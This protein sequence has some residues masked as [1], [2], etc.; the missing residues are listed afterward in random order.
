[1]TAMHAQSKPDATGSATWANP[2]DVTRFT[3]MALIPMMFTQQR[4]S[5]AFR[6]GGEYR[7]FGGV[8]MTRMWSRGRYVARAA[9]APSSNGAI[10]LT[11]CLNGSCEMQGRN[12]F[13]LRAGQAIILP[14]AG[15]EGF[16]AQ[17]DFETLSMRAPASWLQQATGRAVLDPLLCRAIGVADAGMPHILADTMASF[18]MNRRKIGA[19][20][21]DV[22]LA[23]LGTMLRRIFEDEYKDITAASTSRQSL[24]WRVSDDISEHMGQPDLF[25]VERTAERLGKSTRAMQAALRDMGTNFTTLARELRL[26][27]AARMLRSPIADHRTITELSLALGFEDIAHFS[28]SFR[29]RFGLSP[30]QYRAAPPE[31]A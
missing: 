16:S 12:A 5:E 26:A 19:S 8:S 23:T 15:I 18:W 17:G 30:R 11:L 9:R 13:V 7:E 29:R 25:G 31:A 14:C 4:G 10:L 6:A 27:Q 3:R 28:R 1:M 24:Y 22:I 21:G 2:G 20:D